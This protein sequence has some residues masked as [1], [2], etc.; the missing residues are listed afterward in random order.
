MKNEVKHREDL[1]WTLADEL[2]KQRAVS[3]STMMGYPC[4]RYNGAFFACVER[5]SGNLIVKLPSDRVRE[6][7]ASGTALPFAPNGRTFREWA[8]IPQPDRD[9]WR[10]LLD[11]ARR[12]AAA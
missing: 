12:F 4:L 3:R 8:A 11:E 5:S 6:L 7:I 2:L 9:E 1:F 10:A